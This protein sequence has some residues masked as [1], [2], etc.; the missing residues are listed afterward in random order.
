MSIRQMTAVWDRALTDDPSTLL[1]ML[2]LADW[3]NDEGICWPAVES[4]AEKCRI[5]ERQAQRIIKSLE[6][7]GALT[8]IRKSGR[9]HTNVYQLKVTDSHLLFDEKV[10]FETEKVTFGA[11]KGDIAM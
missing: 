10:T 9:K 1:V 2:A 4:I 3:A 5:S 8:V 11:V 7:V 6:E